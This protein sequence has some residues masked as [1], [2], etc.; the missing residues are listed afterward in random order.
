[1]NRACRRRRT[2][3]ESDDERPLQPE[4]GRWPSRSPTARS[5]AIRPAPPP[6]TSP[7][8]SRSRSARPRSPRASTGGSSTSRCRSRRTSRSPSSPRRTRPT[9]LGLIRHDC[10][11]IM[12]RAVQE[13]WPDVKVTIGPVIE[14]GWYYDFDRAEAFT[15]DDL[16][17]IEARMREIIALRDPVR[18]RGLGPRPRDPPLRGDGRALQ[19]RARRGDPRRRPDPDVLAR[20][21]AGPLP[22]AAPRQHRAGAARRLQAHLDRRRLLARR[23]APADAPA[24]LRRRLPHQGR[25]R[26]LPP[27]HRGGGE[28]RPPR[29]SRGRWTSSTSSRRRRARSSGTRTASCSGGRSRPTSAGGCDADGYVEVKTPQLLDT[30]AVADL[31]PLGQVPREHV[32]RARRGAR[33]LGRGGRSGALRQGRPDGAEADEL[34]RPH[35]DL[36]AGHQVLPRPAAAH[37]RVRLLPPQRGPRRAARP[38]ARA[39]AHPG[40]RAH[41]LPRGPDLRGDRALPRALRPGLRRLGLDRHRLQARDAARPAGRRRRHLGP[42]RGRARRRPDRGGAE[43]RPRARRGRLLRPE[44]RVPPDRRHRPDLA[45]RHL[46][47][48][49]R[50]ARALRRDLRR[51]GRRPPPAGD[52]P[53]RDPRHRSSAS[54]AC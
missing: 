3:K 34:P 15:P 20:A 32:H 28:A 14:N 36:Q 45:V 44:A 42:R 18:W 29:A 47:A 39:P 54:S 8:T 48:R 49:L 11:H 10:A 33:D 24:H 19:G 16:G 35:P 2:H 7:P 52:A 6:A 31:G 51:R 37:G 46:P 26:R 43:V 4:S 53:P 50:A 30:P 25:P 27:P 38:A 1:M 5:A 13:L 41:L 22:R 21:V 17:A 12:A 40:R 9:A 23:F